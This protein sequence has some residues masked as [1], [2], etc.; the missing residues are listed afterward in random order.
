MDLARK[1]LKLGGDDP[2]ILAICGYILLALGGQKA[3]GLVTVR[4]AVKANPNN[5]TVLLHG[6]LCNVIAGDLEEGKA[7][8]RRAFELCPGAAELYE[9]MSGLGFASFFEGNYDAA[10]E[11]LQR[12]LATFTEWPPTYWMLAAAYAHLDRMEEARSTLARLQQIAPSVT[13]AAL[14]A[15]RS[16]AR[17]AA[18]RPHDFGAA[19]GGAAGDHHGVRFSEY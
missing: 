7:C 4:R 18:L 1:A 16:P 10:V 9:C 12:S 13:L 11:W 17:Q 6:G 5:V 2:L 15:S 8:Y 14:G 3:D 19:Q